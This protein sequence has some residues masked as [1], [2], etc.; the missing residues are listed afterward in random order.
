M[1]QEAW[2]YQNQC[3]IAR[4][5]AQALVEAAQSEFDVAEKIYY[6]AGLQLAKVITIL[7]G[8]GYRIPRQEASHVQSRVL[9]SEGQ[10]I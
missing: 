3:R 9:I 10:D 5:S 7:E 4:S 8:A 1:F 6:E 2:S